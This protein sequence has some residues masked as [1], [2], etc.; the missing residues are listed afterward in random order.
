MLARSTGASVIGNFA[1]ND[2]RW[3]NIWRKYSAIIVFKYPSN[4]I[5]KLP[6]LTVHKF[7]FFPNAKS[8]THCLFQGQRE[9][10][11]IFLAVLAKLI[12]WFLLYIKTRQVLWCVCPALQVSTLFAY[13]PLVCR[14]KLSRGQMTH[15]CDSSFRVC[16]EKCR[17]ALT[18]L[19]CGPFFEL[20][21]DRS[22][23]SL[24]RVLRVQSSRD[25][26]KRCGQG[27]PLPWWGIFAKANLFVLLVKARR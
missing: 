2:E 6:Y 23:E 12:Y 9:L 8:R 27:Y 4:H 14:G 15:S 3:P 26:Q 10:K 24:P 17:V 11:T 13:F 20:C 7:L 1:L 19:R 16:V 22:A 5:S 18:A 25:P 21:S